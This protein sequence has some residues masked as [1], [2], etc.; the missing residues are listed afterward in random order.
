M[1]A[2]ISIF[3]L[4]SMSIFVIRIASVA[5][6]LTG[7]EESQA[8]FQSLSAF[9]GTGFT[10]SEAEMIVN[11]PVRRRIVGLLMVI[12]NLGLVT[13]LATLVTSLVN[14]EGEPDAI[15]Q[16]LIWLLCG[17]AL[18]WI[19][20]LN[21]TADRILCAWISRLLNATTL[22]GQRCFQRLLQ[23]GS[24]YSVCE[25]PLP[26]RYA[27]ESGHRL[28]SELENR[29]LSLLAILSAQGDRLEVGSSSNHILQNGDRLI[30]AGAD[31]THETFAGVPQRQ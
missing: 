14:T 4:L 5:L 29:R 7:L 8:R 22:L 18:L 17:L 27:G 12:G 19:L 24:G 30:L 25:H 21:Q 13:V 9:T 15:I 1:G 20:M 28:H 3:V 11:Y 6:R 23:L 2:A 31:E 16:Q 10:T 26:L